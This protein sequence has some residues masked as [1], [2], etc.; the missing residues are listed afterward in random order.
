MKYRVVKTNKRGNI[1]LGVFCDR[2]KAISCAMLDI[3]SEIGDGDC[4]NEGKGSLWKCAG[5]IYDNIKSGNEYFY[6]DCSWQVVPV[7]EDR[8]Y[9][10]M[11]SIRVSKKSQDCE[12]G[13]RKR[14]NCQVERNV[15]I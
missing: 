2:G 15:Q 13:R 7:V 8:T 11:C 10:Y 12:Q 5:E 3:M 1:D 6:A 4:E 14:N 9:T